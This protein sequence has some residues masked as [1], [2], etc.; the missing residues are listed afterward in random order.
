[1]AILGQRKAGERG[2]KSGPFFPKDPG[3]NIAIESAERLAG[4]SYRLM[5]KFAELVAAV[6]RRS[7]EN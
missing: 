2:E 1:M 7:P 3:A 5:A 4:E 6:D